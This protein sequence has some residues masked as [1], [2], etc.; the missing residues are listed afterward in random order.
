MFSIILGKE[1]LVLLRYTN[2]ISRQLHMLA[3][4]QGNVSLA[5]N[6]DTCTRNISEIEDRNCNPIVPI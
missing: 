6:Y 2:V 5:N 4:K 1:K 3:L